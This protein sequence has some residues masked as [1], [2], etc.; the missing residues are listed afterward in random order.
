M[1]AIINYYDRHIGDFIKDTLGLSMLEDGAYNRLLDQV[2]Q[3]ERPLPLDK[4]EIY[5]N[6]RANTA[7]E[8]KAVDYVLGKFFDLR[9]DGYM[10]KRA[11]AMLEEYWDREPAEQNKRENAKV[12]QQRSRERR[13]H[14]FDELRALG[15]TPEFNASTKTLEVELSR[16]TSRDNND[17]SNASVTRDDTATQYPVPNPQSPEGIGHPVSAQPE[18]GAVSDSS[19]SVKLSIAMNAAGIRTQPADPRLIALA[20]QGVTAETAAAACAEAKVSK[21]SEAIKPGYVFAIL[22]RWSADAAK[23]RANGA[24]PPGRPGAI[25]KFDPV[26]YV[27]RNRI[28]S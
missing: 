20:A 16:V 1:E 4:K 13:K 21:P 6:A 2:Y 7:P 3:T 28:M 23:L 9:E 12:R 25:E 17:K 8:R 10:Q 27:N 11:Q 26:A 15:V 24:A 22:E 14:L 18:L 19:A 5:R